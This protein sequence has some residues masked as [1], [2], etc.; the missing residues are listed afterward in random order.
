MASLRRTRAEEKSTAIKAP[1]RRARNVSPSFQKSLARTGLEKIAGAADCLHVHRT[2]RI[3][4]DF[5]SQ[6]A[7]VDVDAS[8]RNESLGA[9]YGVEQL[10]ARKN[11]VGTRREEI[12]QPEF[13][14]AHR[15]GF[16]RARNT[17]SGWIDSQLAHVDQFLRWSARL[18]ASPKRFYA[19]GELARTERFRDVIAGAKLETDNS[20]GLLTLRREDQ[21]RQAVQRDILADLFADFKTGE[22]REHQGKNQKIRLRLAN[23]S[24]PAGAVAARLHLETVFFEVVANQLDDVFVIFNYQDTFHSLSLWRTCPHHTGNDPS[25]ASWRHGF[26]LWTI[27]SSGWRWIRIAIL[28]CMATSSYAIGVNPMCTKCFGNV[29]AR[30]D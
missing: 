28:R 20:I 24:Q 7:D 6:A 29:N 27:N 5:L 18:R 4:F 17:I 10:I 16:A 13:E 30:A 8:R 23:L 14:R 2:L 3:E 12:Q 21:N 22:F 15:H 26:S 9:P 1:T 19:G 11:A 25:R